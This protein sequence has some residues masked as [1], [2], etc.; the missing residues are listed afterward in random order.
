MIRHYFS[1]AVL[2]LATICSATAQATQADIQSWNTSNNARVLFIGSRQLPMVQISIAFD[3]GSARDPEGQHGLAYLTN[4][5]IDEGGNGLTAEQV[6]EQ[7][8]NV[9]AEFSSNSARDMSIFN[10][11]SLSDNSKLSLALDVVAGSLSNPDW[12][13]AALDRERARALVALEQSKQNPGNVVKKQFYQQIYDGHPYSN[14]PTGDESGLAAIKRDDLIEFYRQYMVGANATIAIVGDVDVDEA[15]TIAEKLL[16]KLPAG[17]AAKAIPTVKMLPGLN[18]EVEFASQ[19]S[20]LLLGQAGMSRDDPDYF[21]LYVGNYILGGSGLI[22]RLA[23][24]I[25]EDKGLAYSVYSYF[26][27]M[28]DRGPFLLGLQT[29]GDQAQQARQL[30]IDVL[31][32]FVNNGPTAEELDAAKKNLTGGFALKLDSNK[33]IG[34]QLMSIGFYNL[35]LD[36]LDTYQA[37]V[38]AVTLAQIKDAFQ[39]RIKPDASFSVLVGGGK[40]SS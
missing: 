14:P 9:G 29:R 37:R 16:G 11:R 33:K 31:T 8:E 5:L 20:H 23:V 39:R 4:N 6:A 2:I 34:G 26:I 30:A 28:R 1:L 15:K 24:A 7:L 3:A 40:Y 18:T 22:S 12:P 32:N 21:A 36:Y 25:R 13:Q 10:L 27:P 17:A 38:D 35:P 19:Q